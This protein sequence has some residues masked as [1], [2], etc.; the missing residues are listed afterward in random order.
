MNNGLNNGEQENLNACKN[1]QR[2]NYG[3]K[4]TGCQRINHNVGLPEIL[5]DRKIIH[6][7]KHIAKM[8]INETKKNLKKQLQI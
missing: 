7:T 4:K 6:S 8:T 3:L 5:I 2:K 1:S